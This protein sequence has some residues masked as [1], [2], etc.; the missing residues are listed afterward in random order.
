MST[1]LEVKTVLVIVLLFRQYHALPKPEDLFYNTFM[2]DTAQ[3]PDEQSMSE[4]PILDGDIYPSDDEEI[5]E[6]EEMER[7]QGNKT[8]RP[9]GT[10][11]HHVIPYRVQRT[12]LLP[13]L[14]ILP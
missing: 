12:P 9:R 13:P 5:E 4:M 8:V 14:I 10:W 2:T 6:E 3:N 11:D 1:M 7:M